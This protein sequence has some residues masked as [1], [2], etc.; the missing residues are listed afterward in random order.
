VAAAGVDLRILGDA[1]VRPQGG[2][3]CPIDENGLECPCARIGVAKEDDRLVKSGSEGVKRSKECQVRR[4]LRPRLP[5]LQE[6][7][8]EGE[9]SSE[10]ATDSGREGASAPAARGDC[11]ASAGRAAAG[12]ASTGAASRESFPSVSMTCLRFSHARARAWPRSPI[13]LSVMALSVK[14]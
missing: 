1:R 14:M 10:K 13:L 4:H 8:P 2:R 9:E 3:H 12:G 11:A 5:N 6:V 7:R